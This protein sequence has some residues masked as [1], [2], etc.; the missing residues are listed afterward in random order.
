MLLVM[1]LCPFLPSRGNGV[2][3]RDLES[4]LERG[5]IVLRGDLER[6][7][8]RECDGERDLSAG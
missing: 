4:D 5:E 6:V 3:D 7:G 8:E 1:L 2:L